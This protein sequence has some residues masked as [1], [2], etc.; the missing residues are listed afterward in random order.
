[1]LIQ[2]DESYYTEKYWKA[3]IR[4]LVF[5]YNQYAVNKINPDVLNKILDGR[6]IDY[7][8]HF[9]RMIKHELDI[10]VSSM[11]EISVSSGG[12]EYEKEW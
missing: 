9:Y 12:S 1:M 10:L 4:E 6:D 2:K 5:F 3:R 11:E 7:H 8:I